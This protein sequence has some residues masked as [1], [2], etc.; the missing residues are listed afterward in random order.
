MEWL[1]LRGEE[2]N[3]TKCIWYCKVGNIIGDENEIK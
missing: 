3:G 2:K 1:I